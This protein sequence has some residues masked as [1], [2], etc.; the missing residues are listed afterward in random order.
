MYSGNCYIYIRKSD[1]TVVKYTI[2]GTFDTETDAFTTSETPTGAADNP[3][4]IYRSSEDEVLYVVDR[5]SVTDEQK[6][7]I[8][9]YNYD[10]SAFYHTDWDSGNTP[11]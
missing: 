10:E 11:I 3:F 6:I 1:D 2:T 9:G 5:V 4:F 7:K 8:E